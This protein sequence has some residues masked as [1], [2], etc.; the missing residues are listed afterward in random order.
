MAKLES[1]YLFILVKSLSK[2]EK[3]HFKVYSSKRVLGT[4]N[5]YFK[6]FNEIEKQQTYNEARIREQ[7]IFKDLPTLKKR[8][9]KAVLRS[10]AEFHSSIGIDVRDMLD[11]VEIL[12]SKSL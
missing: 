6:L 9:Y 3:R 10:L 12:Y 7:K 11:Q 1:N 5:I 8:L 4:E 2:A